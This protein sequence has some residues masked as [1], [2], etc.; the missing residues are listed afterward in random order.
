M[1]FRV[2]EEDMASYY[3]QYK[4]ALKALYDQQNWHITLQVFPENPNGYTSYS[5]D[6]WKYGEDYLENLSY[7]NTDGTMLSRSS[8]ALLDGLG[9][10]LTGSNGSTVFEVTQRESDPSIQESM[11]TY[12]YTFHNLADARISEISMNGSRIVFTESLDTTAE[13]WET[14]LILNG[15]GQI[16]RIIRYRINES[17]KILYSELT[18]HDTEAAQIAQIMDMISE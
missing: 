14:V 16:Q 9:C 15:E 12:W 7:L 10:H 6:I 1:K 17:E 5:Q 8:A 4:T 18:V 2:F 3:D 13:A 11:F